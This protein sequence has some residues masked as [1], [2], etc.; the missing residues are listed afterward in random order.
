MALIRLFVLLFAVVS[1]ACAHNSIPTTIWGTLEVDNSPQTNE[2]QPDTITFRPDVINCF[3]GTVTTETVFITISDTFIIFRDIQGDFQ[4]S[5]KIHYTISSGVQGH[6]RL[7]CG[8]HVKGDYYTVD[9]YRE[10]GQIVRIELRE[11]VERVNNYVIFE[12]ILF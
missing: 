9:I 3:E 6:S 2:Q 5:L 7:Y 4:K 10:Q 11:P 1:H 8:H 12:K